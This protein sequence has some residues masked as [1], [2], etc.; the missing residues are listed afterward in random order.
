MFTCESKWIWMTISLLSVKHSVFVAS[1]KNRNQ[2]PFSY[3]VTIEYFVSTSI[4]Q[5]KLI[6]IHR[7]L[8]EWLILQAVQPLKLRH[9][10]VPNRSLMNSVKLS[11]AQTFDWMFFSDG[12][13][14]CLFIAFDFQTLTIFY[15]FLQ[16]IHL[17][18]IGFVYMT[19]VSILIQWRLW[20]WTIFSPLFDKVKALWVAIIYSNDV[21]NAMV[22][23]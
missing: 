16:I 8:L 14:V 18:A 22:L 9:M 21:L 13:K 3:K 11:G 19:K 15:C 17:S 2:I 6:K 1:K 4:V 23:S 10:W 5:D 12:R 7:I 20:P